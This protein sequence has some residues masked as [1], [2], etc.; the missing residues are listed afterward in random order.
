MKIVK[1]KVIKLSKYVNIIEKTI[2]VNNSLEKYHSFDQSDYVSILAI[3]KKN[4]IILV[5]QFRPAL[6]KYTIELPGGLRDKKEKHS[7]TAKRELYEETGYKAKKLTF[8][9]SFHPDSGRLE[10]KIYCYFTDD[11][12]FDKKHSDEKYVHSFEISFQEL[13]KLIKKNKIQHFLHVGIIG[14]AHI[15]GLL[16]LK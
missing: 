10:N 5:K 8:L 13:K 3:S 14:L 2:K 6:K 4:K 1:K 11:I 9:G 16:K 15:R 7:I 12:N